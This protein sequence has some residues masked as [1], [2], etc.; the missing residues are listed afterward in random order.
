M[1]VGRM[2][3]HGT[4]EAVEHEAGGVGSFSVLQEERRH[5]ADDAREVIERPLA[6]DSVPQR[7]EVAAIQE[8]ERAR[9][10]IGGSSSWS[11]CSSRM[12]PRSGTESFRGFTSLCRGAEDG[13]RDRVG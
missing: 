8:G 13:A 5:F 3:V 4:T 11:D 10:R 7:W 6:S 1:S 2:G 12:R 9:G